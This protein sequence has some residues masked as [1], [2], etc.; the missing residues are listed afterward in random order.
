MHHFQNCPLALAAAL[1]AFL[2]A[3]PAAA[4]DFY[5][6]KS[7]EL[8]IGAPPGGGYDIYGRVVARHIGRHIPG[9]PSI[10]PKNMPGAGSA[11]AAGFI[12]NIAPKDGTVIAIIMPGAII[13][14]MLDPKAEKL[15]DP[16]QVDRK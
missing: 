3:A 13:G 11:R 4:Q 7:I 15:F 16:T 10:V 5:A 2:A 1:A 9:N 14:P 8:L 6:G 12:A